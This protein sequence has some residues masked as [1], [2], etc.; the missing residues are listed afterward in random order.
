MRR[1]IPGRFDVIAFV[2]LALICGAI[3]QF[4]S[5]RD[6]MLGI[7]TVPIFL[8]A[9]LRGFQQ[10]RAMAPIEVEAEAEDRENSAD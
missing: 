10:S 1:M 6:Y 9:S 3:V 5:N 8:F 7:L 2:I 4:S